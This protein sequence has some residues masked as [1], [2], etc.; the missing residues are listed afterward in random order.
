MAVPDI[1]VCVDCGG[2]CHRSPTGEPELGW[3]PGD[4]VTFRCEECA[5]VWY[6]EL[7]SDDL[8]DDGD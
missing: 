4:V 5:D 2:R 7:S 1:I 3:E 6:V 8:V